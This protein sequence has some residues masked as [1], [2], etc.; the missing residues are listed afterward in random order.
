EAIVAPA[1]VTTMHTELDGMPELR[2]ECIEDATRLLLGVRARPDDGRPSD[3]PRND[4]Q[5]DGPDDGDQYLLLRDP[6]LNAAACV[7]VPTHDVGVAGYAFLL[8][9]HA[10]APAD[11]IA[12]ARASAA[13]GSS[14]EA[15]PTAVRQQ[16]LAT[17]AIGEHNRRAALLGIAQQIDAPRAIDLIV[18]ADEA[19]LVAI[20]T[21]TAAAEPTAT[22]YAWQFERAA[23]SAL[24]PAMQRDELPPA[25][26]AC[27]L[28]HFGALGN[29]AVMLEMHL[30]GSR[31][32]PAF[33]AAVLEENLA[34]LDDR[35]A[36]VRV[37]AHEWLTANAAVVPDY[38]PLDPRPS[39]RSAL[40]RYAAARADLAATANANPETAAPGNTSAG[41]NLPER[42]R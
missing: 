35:G 39:R 14:A 1:L 26:H 22:D 11:A 27:A 40:R 9:A 38:A 5:P 3:G 13:L 34:A 32:A 42:G 2:F 7:F 24:L 4:S 18:A 37:R 36:A 15:P 31:D 6:L 8:T 33:A 29:D 16:H 12:A 23:W 21:A 28:R 17:L 41:S 20:T 10:D 25:L 19:H 30:R